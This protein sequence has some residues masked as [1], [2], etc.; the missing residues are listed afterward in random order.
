MKV[1]NDRGLSR[2]R[3]RRSEETDLGALVDIRISR[4]Q[5]FK[6]MAAVT[7]S[8]VLPTPL[9]WAAMNG[10]SIDGLPAGYQARLIIA[11]GDPLLP[12]APEFQPFNTDAAVAAKQFGI[13]NDFIA[14]LPLPVQ[15]G[16]SNERALLFAN[17]EYPS[18]ELM[19]P[20][21]TKGAAGSQMSL[22]QIATTMAAIG[23]SVVELEQR[24]DHWYRVKGSKWN[25]RIHLHTPMRISGPVAGH[26]KMKTSADPTG[27]LVLGTLSNC[28]G[29]ITPWGT[30]LTCEEGASW[31]FSGDSSSTPNAETLQRYY[32]DEK[33]NDRFAWSRVDSRFNLQ[34]EP[35]EP[36]RFEWVVEID[37]Y[38]PDSVPVKRT[39]LGRFAHE[40]AHTA[41]AADGR[42]VVYL[43]DDWEFEYC[44]RFVS[45]QAYDPNNRTANQELLDDGILS[46]AHFRGDGVLE[47]RSLVFGQGLLTPANGFASQ[48]DVLINTRKAAD[49]SGATPMDSPEGF[50]PH[51]IN[52]CV[53][54]AL[55]SNADRQTS[56]PANPRA[57]NRYGHLI[58]LHP[59]AQ[60][61]G[62]DHGADQFRWEVLALCGD[63]GQ[64]E[65]G[66][67]FHPE[68]SANGW[69]TDP[70]NISFDHH[71]HMWIC[72]DGVQP[73]GY[74]ALYVMPVDGPNRAKPEL[75]YKPPTGAECCE[76]TLS[77]DGRTLFVAIQ[78]P[79]EGVD[80]LAE[81]ATHWPSESR[82]MPPRAGV[83]AIT[84]LDGGVIV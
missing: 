7:A 25:R 33:D 56:G 83:V 79:G 68:T 80:S 84:R 2:E 4:R 82:A 59:P 27:K 63:P 57:N 62:Y 9:T 31:L 67:S 23:T 49:L 78:H 26:H 36:N 66:A 70:D 53:Y 8:G 39:A 72:T 73:T 76:P 21:I 35:N 10:P 37:P 15:D 18:A 17:H 16:D 64:P 24:G 65:Q 41:L 20:N 47:W 34:E 58:E 45:T 38:D 69:F 6:Y 55:S 75:F 32:Y 48:A 42:V 51:P 60:G 22:E 19:W 1:A 13:N 44:Y 46:V 30:I 71:G 29:G 3:C 54:I 77:R 14:V 28:N 43:G 74:D 40:G 50:K 11:A 52:G 81:V 12:D 61:D 5:M